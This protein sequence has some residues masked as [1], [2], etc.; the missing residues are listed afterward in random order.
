MRSVFAFGL[1]LIASLST[2]RAVEEPMIE[3]VVFTAKCDQSEQRYVVLLPLG[4]QPDQPHDVLIVLH[5]HGSDRW[6]FIRDP[7]DECRAARE[8]AAKHQM[9]YVSPD[10][11]AK[12]SW[13]GPKA[14]ADLVQ[15]IGELRQKHQVSRVFVCG[16][17][18]G[19]TSALAFGVLHP[20]L[21]AGIA[22]MNG[23]A[24]L[25][26]YTGFPDAISESFGGNKAVIPEEYK[27][28]SAEYWPERLR[29]PVAMT[30]GGKDTL[31]P[32][33]SCQRLAGVLKLLDRDVLLIHREQA[34]HSTNLED[35][36]AVIE[37]IVQKARPA[38]DLPPK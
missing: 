23:T 20:E 3:D 5:G 36:K 37:F 21:V 19:G 33:Q 32:P 2:A 24:N 22:S 31:V 10:Y 6:Q 26:E 25:L 27:N 7:R 29:M 15:I 1:A 11:R 8:V 34:G 38:A 16:G 14:E 12:T 4:F 9:L 35:G 28:R 30:T 13:M 17:S 18:M